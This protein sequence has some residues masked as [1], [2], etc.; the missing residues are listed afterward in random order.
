MHILTFL[1]IFVVLA[2]LAVGFIFWMTEG[3]GSVEKLQAR[4]E[5][6]RTALKPVEVQ[7]LRLV[8]LA[9]DWIDKR[10]G[11][12]PQAPRGE[13]PSVNGRLPG[14]GRFD[15]LV[16]DEV[17]HQNQLRRVDKSLGRGYE[18]GPLTA[19]IVRDPNNAEDRNGCKVYIE[20]TRVGQLS[21]DDA[22]F[23]LR[24][25]ESRAITSASRFEVSARLIGGYGDRKHYAVVVDLPI[26]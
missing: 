24:L 6:V 13:L 22:R 21:D 9:R 12:A 14:P 25:L 1:G 2:A 11:V 10:N 17:R 26:R 4:A 19:T 18:D 5:Q 16:I 7:V 3:G 20:T 15:F 8:S 23:Y